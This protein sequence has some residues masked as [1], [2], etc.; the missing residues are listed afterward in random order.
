MNPL[1]LLPGALGSIKQFEALKAELE[2]LN[3]KTYVFDLPGHGLDPY[4]NEA[5]TVPLMAESLLLKW[6]EWG[7]IQPVNIFGHSLGGYIGLYL[8]LNSPHKVNSLFTLGTK[9]KWN[10]ET[11]QK[12]TAFLVPEKMEQK[13]PAYVEQLKNNH[14]QDWKSLVNNIKWLMDDLGHNMYLD[15]EFLTEIDKKVRIGL[16]DR[17]AMVSLEETINVYKTLTNAQLQIYPNTPHPF[18]KSDMKRL[19]ADIHNFF[20]G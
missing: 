20:Y 3:V 13:I 19:S 17:D 1:I 14:A 12:E 9:W 10:Q 4:T 11:A 8:C 6:E 18:E 5:I 2:G 15:Q 7:I 16:G